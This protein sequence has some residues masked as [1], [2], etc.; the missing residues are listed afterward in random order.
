M[1]SANIV[2]G[3]TM[4]TEQLNL[5]TQVLTKHPIFANWRVIAKAWYFVAPSRQLADAKVM[6]FALYGQRIVVFR[7]QDGIVRA[8]DAFCPHMGADLAIGKVVGQKIQCFFHHWQFDGAGQCVNIPC[9][10]GSQEPAP[11]VQ[12]R[13][14]HVVERYQSIWIWPDSKADNELA[15]FPDPMG[16]HPVVWFGRPTYRPCHHHVSMINGLDPQHLKTVH[17]ISIDMNVTTKQSGDE[18]T[19]DFL[20][21]G[22]FPETASGRLLRFLFGANYSYSMRYV[23]ASIGLLTTLRGLRF[24]GHGFRW[25]QSTMI[26]AYVPVEAGKTLVQ[27]IFLTPRRRGL[28]GFLVGRLMLLAAYAGFYS[29]RDEDGAIY[30]HIRFNTRQL[31]KMDQPLLQFIQY[32]NRLKPSVWSQDRE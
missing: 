11:H 7:G 18:Q 22:K 25:P 28:F 3:G 32:V 31:L 16:D 21:S 26:F 13:S 10:E 19:I 5:G 30:D 4:L 9:L 1:S 8:L 12:T 17:N 2:E 27:P 24:R 29:L 6:S 14:Y 20:L 15:D 23:N